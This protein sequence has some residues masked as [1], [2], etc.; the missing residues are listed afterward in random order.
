MNIVLETIESALKKKESG[1]ICVTNSR[2]TYLANHDATYCQIQ[3]NSLLSVPDGAP[4]VWI[5]HNLGHKDVGKVSG[6]DLMDALFQIS[7]KNKYSHYFFGSTPKTIELLKNNIQSNYAGIDIKGAVSPP[8]QPLEDFDIEGLAKNINDLRPTFFWCGLGAPKQ[9]QFIALLQ[10][11]LENTICVGVG[12]AFEY[13]AGTVKRAPKWIQK[14]GF[15]GILNNLRD[16]KRAKRFI[17]P[18]FLILTK[19]IKSYA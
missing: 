17:K 5:A 3:N 16:P 2:T 9:E 7:L 15:E 6:K 13:I 8:F 12:L 19:L 14:S 10:P 4:L 11:K 18:F 1:Y